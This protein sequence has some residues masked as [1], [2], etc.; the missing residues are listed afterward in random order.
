MGALL[1]WLFSFFTRDTIT[2]QPKEEDP[3]P[4]EFPHL[5]RF[6]EG[7]IKELTQDVNVFIT[8]TLTLQR[9]PRCRLSL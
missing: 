6:C 2:A 4:D 5:L 8:Q 9:I 1:S 7:A 3:I